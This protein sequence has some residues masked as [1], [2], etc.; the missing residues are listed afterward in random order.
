MCRLGVL[1]FLVS[2][3]RVWLTIFKQ[4]VSARG[5]GNYKF[6]RL[7]ILIEIASISGFGSPSFI[8]MRLINNSSRGPV[9]CDTICVWI[10][11]VWPC[12]FVSILRSQG[13]PHVFCDT[14]CMCI[15]YVWPGS[16]VSILW[17][18]GF[19]TRAFSQHLHVNSLCLTTLVRFKIA[20]HRVCRSCPVTALACEFVMFGR[21]LSRWGCGS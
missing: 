14:V 7:S 15:C 3:W 10:C 17:V 6:P 11:Y 9:F 18:V 13:L 20:G 12:S 16:F 5:F 19:T 21:V 2:K 8:V 1:D 4:N